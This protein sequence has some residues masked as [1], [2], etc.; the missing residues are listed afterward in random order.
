[1]SQELIVPGDDSPYALLRMNAGEA[2]TIIKDALGGDTLSI[3]DLDRIK[4]PSGG[5][6]VW[7]IPS[8]DGER[9][10]KEL[11]GVI[12]HKA[13]RRVYWD[14]AYGEEDVDGDGK[15]ACQS[16]DGD[17]GVGTPGGSCSSCPLNE[18]ETAENG[19]GKAC[20]ETRQLFVLTEND[21]LPI[22]ITVPPAS[23][24]AFRD[25][26]L[27]LLR[28]QLSASDVVTRLTLKKET[29]K[30]N[31]KIKFSKIEFARAANLGPDAVSRI[32]AYEQALMP[33]ITATTVTRDETDPI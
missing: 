22:A 27:R 17:F 16:N 19:K 3:R 31:D 29:A 4:V 25:Y 32:K 10:E 14:K 26:I 5:G 9:A 1:M 11:N 13:T 6:T 24:G 33:A 12:I 8:L 28:A 15:P 7:E 2:V 18:W 20:R 21:L 30:D 23:L